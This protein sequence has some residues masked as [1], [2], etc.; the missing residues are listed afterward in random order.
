MTDGELLQRFVGRHD[1][2]A[3]DE[4]VRRHVDFV[5]AAAR[6]QLDD[7]HLA[8]D[9]TQAVFLVLAQKAGRV[10]AQ[11][12]T[13]WLYRTTCY[14]AANFRKVAARRAYHER[15]AAMAKAEAVM[16]DPASNL[17]ADRLL[18]MLDEGLC[19]L[20]PRDREALILRYL[21]GRDM[22]AVCAAIGVAEPAARKRITRAVDK[23]RVYFAA[24]GMSAGNPGVIAA[25][26]IAAAQKAP[27]ETVLRASAAA[28]GAGG[29]AVAAIAKAIAVAS[30]M[31]KAKVAALALATVVICAAVGTVVVRQ[32]AK[33][34]AAVVIAQPAAATSAPAGDPDAY[35]ALDAIRRAITSPVPRYYTAFHIESTSDRGTGRTNLGTDTVDSH[36]YRDGDNFDVQFHLRVHWMDGKRPDAEFGNRYIAA[37]HFIGYDTVGKQPPR[38]GLYN[39][40]GSKLRSF[41]IANLDG[42]DVL[43]GYLGGDPAPFWEILAACNNLHVVPEATDQPATEPADQKAPRKLLHLA[44]KGDRG[45]YDLWCDP[46]SYTLVAA[47]VVKGAGDTVWGNTIVGKPFPG[48]KLALD[49]FHFDLTVTGTAS[50]AS[51]HRVDQATFVTYQHYSDGGHIESTYKARRTAFEL[52]PD[53]AA[54]GAFQP[55]LA[56]NTKLNGLNMGGLTRFVWHNHAAELIPGTS[57]PGSLQAALEHSGPPTAGTGQSSPMLKNGQTSVAMQTTATGGATSGWHAWLMPLLIATLIVMIAAV[58]IVLALRRGGKSEE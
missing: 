20:G 34:A 27:S 15:R 41:A 53:F 2:A 38:S 30:A 8:E 46:Q 57:T 19:S 33:S 54:R 52:N 11:R 50:D 36:C 9:V 37:A 29:P 12:L 10:P 13:G 18:E 45:Q 56:E 4:L 40:D 14:A 55:E 5:Y 48:S 1:L 35:R 28:C 31:A 39:P 42:G 49:G 47:K 24:R 21:Q 58:G 25:L 3:M 23:L 26:S 43:E 7:P 6:R 51:F 22:A 17:Q 16:S 32:M 44:G